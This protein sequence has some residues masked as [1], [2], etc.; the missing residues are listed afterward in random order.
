[1]LKNFADYCQANGTPIKDW[2]A[3]TKK[4]FDDFRCSQVCMA[5]TEKIDALSSPTP[6]PPPKH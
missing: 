1:M 6:A 4:D 5:A 2:T 3:V